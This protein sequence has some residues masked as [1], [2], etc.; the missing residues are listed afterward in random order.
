MTKLQEK[1]QLVA[2]RQKV[3]E[4]TSGKGKTQEARE[5]LGKHRQDRQT[6]SEWEKA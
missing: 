3:P 2:V 6:E 1:K 4:K 5:S